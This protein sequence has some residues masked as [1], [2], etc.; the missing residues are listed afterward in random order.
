V[1]ASKPPTPKDAADS[2]DKTL[3]SA[4]PPAPPKP[5]AQPRRTVMQ[6]PTVTMGMVN[7]QQNIPKLPPVSTTEQR[8]SLGGNMNIW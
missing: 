1:G 4:A 5:A 2:G 6:I 7:M 8:F 3:A